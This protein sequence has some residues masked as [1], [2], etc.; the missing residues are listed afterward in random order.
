[1]DWR[2]VSNSRV[3]ALQ[4]L[5]PPKKK[6]KRKIIYCSAVDCDGEKLKSNCNS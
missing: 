5:V 2:C 1:M 4:T 6:K 3:P